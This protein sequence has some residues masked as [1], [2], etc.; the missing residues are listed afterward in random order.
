VHYY[1][2]R[3]VIIPLSLEDFRKLLENAKKAVKRPTSKDLK[4]LFDELSELALSSRDEKEWYMSIS[5]RVETAFQ[6]TRFQHESTM[7]NN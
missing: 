4:Y 6:E 7:F 2:G 3:S 1:G 5:N